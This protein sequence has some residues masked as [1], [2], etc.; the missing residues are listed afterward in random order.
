MQSNQK[1]HD[2]FSLKRTK[3][4]LPSVVC[5]CV[6]MHAYMCVWMYT[7]HT[8]QLCVLLH[9]CPC[10]CVCLHCI[11][12]LCV[13]CLYTHF[14]H[15]I[16]LLLHIHDTCHASTC[17]PMHFFHSISRDVEGTSQEKCVGQKLG[18][19]WMAGRGVLYCYG[20]QQSTG[21]FPFIW[22]FSGTGCC[23]SCQ[24]CFTPTVTI[25]SSGWNKKQYKQIKAELYRWTISCQIIMKVNMYQWDTN[26]S[27]W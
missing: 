11:H 16:S 12:V 27:D 9:I 17:L 5:V 23:Q 22:F 1:A 2:K 25:I 24:S 18:G 13:C 26:W 3:K 4:P 6:H 21:S 8:C 14:I 19:G 15:F 10:M 20:S 7:L